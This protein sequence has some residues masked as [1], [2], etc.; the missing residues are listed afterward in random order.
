MALDLYLSQDA[1]ELQHSIAHIRHL[2]KIK[3]AQFFN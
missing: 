1:G 2:Q 3:K